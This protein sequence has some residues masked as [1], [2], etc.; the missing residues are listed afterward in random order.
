MDVLAGF[1]SRFGVG[2]GHAVVHKPGEVVAEA[3][4]AA[5]VAVEAREHPVFDDAEAPRH[6]GF[7]FRDQHLAAG[8]AHDEDHLVFL[9][10]RERARHAGVG[11]DDGDPDRGAFV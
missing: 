9:R 1:V 10:F 8:G 3:R 7:F 5:F 2:R 11:V 6:D 4:L